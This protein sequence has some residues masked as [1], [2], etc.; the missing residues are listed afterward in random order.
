MDY[1]LNTLDRTI[2]YSVPFKVPALMG[3]LEAVRYTG[4][5]RYRV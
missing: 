5:E 1:A 3:L 4:A 2:F